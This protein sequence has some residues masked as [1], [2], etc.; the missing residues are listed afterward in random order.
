MS[1]YPATG[2]EMPPIRG[3]VAGTTSLDCMRNT[4]ARGPTAQAQEMPGSQCCLGAEG[5]W[6][7]GQLGPQ[8]S[9]EDHVGGENTEAKWL[10]D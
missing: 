7:L 5:W 9:C 3:L 6:G 2:A 1:Q 4:C 8:F 10:Q